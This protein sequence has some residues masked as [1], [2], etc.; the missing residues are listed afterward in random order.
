MRPQYLHNVSELITIHKVDLV[1]E[2]ALDKHNTYARQFVEGLK[3]KLKRDIEWKGVDLSPDERKLVPD[4]NPL[5]IGTLCD[6]DFQLAREWAWVVRTSK[7]MKQ[8]A[9]FICG[10]SHA[11]SLSEKFRWAGFAVETHVFFDKQDADRI[12]NNPT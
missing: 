1:A 12:R 11:L 10:W 9:L 6:L 2:E 7:A 4:E 8:S 5:G 3:T